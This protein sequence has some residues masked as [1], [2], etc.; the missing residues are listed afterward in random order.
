MPVSDDHK[1]PVYTYGDPKNIVIFKTCPNPQLA[2]KFLQYL[3]EEKNELKF[4]EFTNQ[5]PRRKNLDTNP[6]F[7]DYFNKN[8]KM[9]I[10]AEQAKYV[11]GTDQS[12]VLKEVFDL[13]SQEY[14]ACVIYGMKTP[15]AA[16]SDAAKAVNLLFLK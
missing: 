4:L 11:K 12:P 15:E 2:W 3:L 14:E 8:P 1:G 10:F 7:K 6:L 13:I 5:L 9:K 16:V